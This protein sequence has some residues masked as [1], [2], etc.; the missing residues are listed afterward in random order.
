MPGEPSTT[1]WVK[2]GVLG[3]AHGLKGEIYLRATI[4]DGKVMSGVDTVRVQGKDMDRE[5]RVDS[6]RTTNTGVLLGLAGVDDRDE[7]SRMTGCSLLVR[8]EDFPEQQPGEFYYSDLEGAPVLDKHGNTLGKVLYFEEY[9]TDLMFFDW[10]GHGIV[11][12]PMVE[13]FVVKIRNNPASIVIENE[14][15]SELLQG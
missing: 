7:A 15:L 2:M 10:H 11:A 13:D 3:R 14:H 1:R 6:V 4:Q 12:L 8:R 9:G 5:Y